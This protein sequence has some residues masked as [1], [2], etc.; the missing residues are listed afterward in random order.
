MA[1]CPRCRKEYVE[2]VERCLRCR[3]LLLPRK[4]ARRPVSSTE[5]LVTIST[6]YGE[7]ESALL[8]GW[9]EQEGIA[10]VVRRESVAQVLGVMVDGLGVRHLQV[11]ASLAEEAREALAALSFYPRLRRERLCRFRRR[12]P[13]LPGRTA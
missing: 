11:P 10:V 6:T 9:L 2:N 1:Y 13:T 3:R 8:Q 12:R 5:K 7:L 4:P